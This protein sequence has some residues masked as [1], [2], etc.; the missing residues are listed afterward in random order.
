VLPSPGG[1]SL[2]RLLNADVG[3]V[4]LAVVF[5]RSHV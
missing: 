2:V 3:S 5:R 1:V 4:V